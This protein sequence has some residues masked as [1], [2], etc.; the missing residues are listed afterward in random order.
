MS[1]KGSGL[2]DAVIEE[3]FGLL[4][5]GLLYVEKLG[6]VEHCKA[7]LMDCRG[8][9]SNHRGK[10]ELKGLPPAIHRQQALTAA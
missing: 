1:R 2:D 5:R 10:A 6:C 8:Y 9:Y 7:E 3:F 4:K